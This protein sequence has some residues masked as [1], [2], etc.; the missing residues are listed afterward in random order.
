MAI[1]SKTQLATDI[2]A[3]IGAIYSQ[4]DIQQV[5]GDI[6]DSYEDI[7]AQ[8]T[9]VQRDALTPTAGLII[10][11]TDND[12]YEYWDGVQWQ[13]MNS[14]TSSMTVKV[15]L[16]SAQL[17]S[18]YT[19]PIDLISAPGAGYFIMPS[20]IGYRYTFGTAVYNFTDDLYIGCSTGTDLDFIGMIDEAYIN[21]G[22]NKSG[23]CELGIRGNAFIEND[24][25]VFRATTANATTGDG[26]L[27]LWIT[28]TLAQ[29]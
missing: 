20:S 18:A 16:T 13:A 21:A 11:N 19:T 24:K 14:I 27:S 7:F 1:K 26:V 22:S 2:S 23:Y 3:N 6:V 10:F 25:I 29:W 28:Y 4:T 8:L 15:S 12:R 17:L 5:L 9:T